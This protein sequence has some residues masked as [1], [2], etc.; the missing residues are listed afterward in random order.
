MKD[1]VL[2]LIAITCLILTATGSFIFVNSFEKEE[3]IVFASDKHG[4]ILHANEPNEEKIHV[5]VVSA[6]EFQ[7]IYQKQHHLHKIYETEYTTYFEPRSNE[8]KQI[9]NIDNVIKD[10]IVLVKT[11]EGVEPITL[12]EFDEKLSATHKLTKIYEDK[13]VVYFEAEER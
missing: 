5:K 1:K 4:N 13:V 8:I 10:R 2:I 12:K 7:N 11:K 3:S 6:E 9:Q